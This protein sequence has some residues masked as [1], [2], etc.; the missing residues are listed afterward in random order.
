MKKVLAAC[1]ALCA[2][3]AAFASGSAESGQG[4]FKGSWKLGGSTTVDP[5]VRGAI[6][7]FAKKYPAAKLSYDSQGSGVGINGVLTGV[8]S[9]G[10]S[11]RELTDEEKGK[12]LVENVIALDGLAVIANTSIP[13]ADLPRRQIADLFNGTIRNWKEV[14]GPDKPVVV[15]TRDEASGTRVAFTELVLQKEYDKKD[16]RASFRK[17]AITVESNGDMVS[18]VGATPDSIGYCGEGYLEQA[19]SAGAKPVSVNGIAASEK[20]VLNRTYPVSRQLYL[21]SK[22]PIK[23]GT[24]EMA[25]YEFLLSADGQAIVKQEGFIPVSA[26]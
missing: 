9:L 20:T 4:G 23:D 26:R 2:A 17:D 13:L 8:Y 21:I 7:A 12:G 24:L 25:F 22:G 19:I 1:L 5:I 16:P 3:A 18:R 11:S 10:G 14:G 6:E 15:V